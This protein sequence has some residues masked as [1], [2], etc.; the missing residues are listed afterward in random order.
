MPMR[1][2]KHKLKRKIVARMDEATRALCYAHRH[3]LPGVK[4]TKLED[5]QKLLKKKDGSTPS[6]SAIA[7]A[8]ESFTQPKLK[9][10][11]KKGWRKTT[12]AEDK[13]LMVVFHKAR[14]PGCGIDSRE[15]H[16]KLPK[17]LRAKA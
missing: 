10:G 14:P 16:K 1:V 15:L 11:R 7:E 5:L 9:R 3:P 17:N 12:K 2:M 6:I 8:A 4:K 13:K